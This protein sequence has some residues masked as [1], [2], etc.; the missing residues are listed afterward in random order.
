[1]HRVAQVQQVRGLV[2][3][4]RRA[5]TSCTQAECAVGKAR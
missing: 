3:L 2:P 1:L 5:S 4:L